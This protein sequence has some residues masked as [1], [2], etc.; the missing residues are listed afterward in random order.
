ME[1]IIYVTGNKFKVLTANKI[2]GPLGI[3]VEA[4]KIDCPEIQ[5][6]SIEEVAMYSSKYASEFLGCDTLKNDS[7]L[8]IPAL[9]GFPGPYTHYVE[10]TLTEDGILKLMTGVENRD[11]YF[12]EVLAYTHLNEKPIVFVSKTEGKIAY[13]KSGEYGWSY[14]RIFIPNGSDKTLACYSDDDR[15]QFWDDKAYEQLA[16]YLNQYQ[17]KR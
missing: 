10:D 17:K 1:K 13:E 12:L 11:A 15:W 2:L 16:E 8:V 4:K 14:D 6:D 9:G 3:E 5:A 7:G